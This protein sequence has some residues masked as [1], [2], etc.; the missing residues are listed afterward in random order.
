MYTKIIKDGYIRIKTEFGW[1]AEHRYVM[2]KHIGRPLRKGDL[3]GNKQNNDIKNLQ[4]MTT[5][6]HTIHHNKNTIYT[7]NT[8]GRHGDV[9]ALAHRT[10][11][12]R[13]QRGQRLFVGIGAAEG[14]FQT[15]EEGTHGTSDSFGFGEYSKASNA[16]ERRYNCLPRES[17]LINHKRGQ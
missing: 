1:M 10:A 14:D 3:D 11:G 16:G 17:Q 9:F 2:R 6:E 7:D 15:G 5:K 12:V 4:L 8:A 13:F